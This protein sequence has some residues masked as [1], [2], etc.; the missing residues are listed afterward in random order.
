MLYEVITETTISQEHV[1]VK[2]I[3]M[4]HTAIATIHHWVGFAAVGYK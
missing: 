1:P 2:D 4:G 3:R